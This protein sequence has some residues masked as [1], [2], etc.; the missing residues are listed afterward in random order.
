MVSLPKLKALSKVRVIRCKSEKSLQKTEERLIKMR[1]KVAVIS[2]KDYRALQAYFTSDEGEKTGK[3]NVRK[4]EHRALESH[5][6]SRIDKRTDKD[7]ERKA[8]HRALQA[9]FTS[10]E[11][12]K[13]GKDDERKAQ[14]RAM[15]SYFTS[16]IDKKTGKDNVRN[17]QHTEDKPVKKLASL[18][19]IDVI[20]L[21]D[22][23]K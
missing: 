9:Y 12:E 22:E 15:E 19:K 3:G 6:T 4:A 1:K 13:T 20:L 18:S 2:E 14:H 21:L 17:A 10:D 23:N 8:Q 11:G 5:F 7:D 16:R